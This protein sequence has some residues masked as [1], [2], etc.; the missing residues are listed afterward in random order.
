MRQAAPRSRDFQALAGSVPADSMA[1]A[2]ASAEALD[3]LLREAAKH[4]GS[5]GWRALVFHLSKLQRV[6]RRDK[7]L[8]IAANMLQDLVKKHGGSLFQLPNHDLAIVCKG[9]RTTIVEDAVSTL[10][11]LF[12]DDPLAHRAVNESGFAR[13]STWN[14]STP[15]SSPASAIRSPAR[16][17][18]GGSPRRRR[19]A[20]ARRRDR[21]STPA[22]SPSC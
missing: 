4:D 2:V 3:A 1:A 10:K 7:H 22:A 6:H 15:G 9:I 11:Y 8:Q 18:R 14:G 13:A 17:R 20:T 5:R 12:N 19:R 16:P 21:R